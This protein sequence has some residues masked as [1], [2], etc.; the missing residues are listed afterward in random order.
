MTIKAKLILGFS[1]IL[2]LLLAI[3]A[4]AFDRIKEFDHL[5]TEVVQ[6]SALKR[7]HSTQIRSLMNQITFR[8]T[9]MLLSTNAED[10]DRLEK[11]IEER[12]AAFHATEKEL[13]PLLNEIGRTEITEMQKLFEE[14]KIT[15]AETIRLSKAQRTEEAIRLSQTVLNG[16][17]AKI[18]PFF[19]TFE[20]RSNAELAEANKTAEQVVERTILI[21]SIAAILSL[22][23]GIGFAI[24]IIAGVTKSLTEVMGIVNGVS[25]ASEQV[26]ATALNLSQAASE[27]ASSLE[28]TTA[29][30][31]EISSSITQNSDNARSTNQIAMSSTKNA[32]N[33]REAVLETLNAMREISSKINIIEEIAYQTNLLALNA[34]IE[35]AR[36]GKHG[37]GFAVVAD[38][39][40]KLAER[41]QIAAQEINGLSSNSV[42][43]AEDAGNLINEIVPEIEQTA[44][45]VK[46]ITDASEEQSRGV[47]EINEAML[48]LD[49]VT[50]ENASASEELAATSNEMNE[51]IQALLDI[52]NL[53]VHLKEENQSKK[54]NTKSVSRGKSSPK[55]ELQKPNTKVPLSR[56][57]QRPTHASEK[58]TPNDQAFQD[59]LEKEQTKTN[60]D[61]KEERF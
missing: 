1:T 48:Q 39:V 38:E 10:R 24:W 21:V 36:A 3:S 45:L 4:L 59:V 2:I 61:I 22:L 34:A 35:A 56:M 19:A 20:T 28:E 18:I 15:L 58:S 11:E 54:V 40:R 31:E 29:S 25:S 12:I 5:L 13:Y 8:E 17:L 27:Q 60:K 32:Q 14:F 51:Q 47:Q 57:I 9:D 23:L 26:S 41:S 50:Q 55:V 16:Q 49:S 46:E 43:L 7:Y 52:V 42:K 37:K 30:L 44:G 33:G 6:K 53:L